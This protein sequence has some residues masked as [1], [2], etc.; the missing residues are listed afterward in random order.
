MIDRK[1][2][3]FA[4]LAKHQEQLKKFGV[5]RWGVFGSFAREQQTTRSDVD[6]LVEFEQGKKSFDNFMHLAFFLEEQV[7]RRIELVTPESLSPYIGPHILREVE[8]ASISG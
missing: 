2:D 8:Y 5:K 4:L 7:G 1:K 3:L 6:I